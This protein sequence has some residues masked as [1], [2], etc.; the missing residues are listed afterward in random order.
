MTT[1]KVS[2]VLPSEFDRL[3]AVNPEYAAKIQAGLDELAS[4]VKPVIE[5]LGYGWSA[6]VSNDRIINLTYC[7]GHSNLAFNDKLGT[8]EATVADYTGGGFGLHARCGGYQPSQA[9]YTKFTFRGDYPQ[10]AYHDDWYNASSRGA[11]SATIDL[12]NPK[13]AAQQINRR[14]IPGVIEHTAAARKNVADSNLRLA[15][16]STNAVAVAK[17][18]KSD[19]SRIGDLRDS[20]QALRQDKGLWITTNLR[21]SG[22]VKL[23]VDNLTVNQLEQVIEFIT[24]KLS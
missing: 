22:N 12:K 17:I 11:P 3:L 13:S 2:I 24:S 19:W 8:T 5:Q 7:H 23:E 9:S 10:P 4:L 15:D 6:T 20:Y 18:M 21:Q 14:L 16:F 1:S